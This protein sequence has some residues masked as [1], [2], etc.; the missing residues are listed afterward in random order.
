MVYH[1]DTTENLKNW[2]LGRDK[3]KLSCLV[4]SCVQTV[5]TDKTRQSCHVR[6]DG[7]NK[8]LGSA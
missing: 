7:V 5:D 1:N 3:T 6:V 8:L 4:S 2:K